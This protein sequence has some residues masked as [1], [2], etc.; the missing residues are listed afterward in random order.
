MKNIIITI[1]VLFSLSVAAQTPPT[2][3]KISNKTM[4]LGLGAD[5]TLIMPRYAA[6]PVGMRSGIPAVSGQI[7]LD[8]V[9]H[10]PYYFSDAWLRFGSVY[11]I[12]LGYGLSGTSPLTTTGT[13]VADTAT[14]FGDLYSTFNLTTTGT[15]AA[16][17]N[18]SVRTLN[19]PTPAAA[20]NANIGSGYRWAIPNTT[21]IKTFFVT[22]PVTI[23]STTNT[24]ALT[25]GLDTASGKWR[26]ENYYNTI[27]TPLTRSI[28][29]GYGLTGGGN[30]SA[31]RTFIADSATLF[32]NLI[33]TISLTTTGTSGAATWNTS[34]RTLNIPQYQAAGSYV[35]NVT[36]TYPAASSGGATPDISIDTSSGKWRSENY[37]NTVYTPL[38]RSLVKG[39]GIANTLGNFT[40]DRTVTVDSATIF[41]NLLSTVA[42]TT[43]GTTGA[44]TWN[45][46]TRILN[47]PNYSAGVADV[48][49]SDGSGFDFTITGTTT[50]NIALT[51]SLTLGSVPFIGASGALSQD[52][53]QL[54]WDDTDN[55]LG[56]GLNSPAYKLDVLANDAED[57]AANIYNSNGGGHGLR[58]DV[59]SSS[60]LSIFTAFAGSSAR[61][62]VRSDGTVLFNNQAGTSGYSLLSRGNGAPPVWKL[63]DTSNVNEVEDLV[64]TAF[65]G[66]LTVEL[67][68]AGGS[69]IGDF[70]LVEGTGIDLDQTGTTSASGVSVI[71]ISS[72]YAGQTSITTLGTIGTGTWQ[73][74]SISTTY[75]D[76]KLKTLTGTADR[77][78]I[79]GTS[80]DPTVDIASTYVG[81]SSITTLGTIGAGTWQGTSISTTY[82]D[83][84]IKTVTGTSDRLTI[85]GTST[86]PTFDISTSYVGQ[87]T[88]TTVGTIT[89]GVWNGTDIAYSNI[90]QL[91]AVSLLGNST[92]STATVGAISLGAGL[93][94]SG[95]SLVAA[96]ASDTN[97]IQTFSSSG[98]ASS[99]TWT[100]ASG[101]SL[102][103]IA[104]TNITFDIGG[105]SSDPTITINASLASPNP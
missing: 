79:G 71:S 93:S 61:F 64:S 57:Y 6:E 84:K 66:Q 45:P 38:T 95:G 65:A 33:S 78:T 88:I 48:T 87:N 17:W 34:T 23:D 35:T 101:G 99:L 42:L 27:Y 28:S 62:D 82:T 91:A 31:N 25:V 21:N 37:Y 86:D 98:D 7:A 18:A 4:H 15:G 46:T 60:N 77:I 83:A 92:G 90:E 14:M 63:A 50:K 100:L 76:A 13:I 74:T 24:N 43:T 59:N 102:Q 85:G 68:S 58:V 70:A 44:A 41:P 47:I 22:A 49:A 9:N 16:T 30:F 26:S 11:N 72:T 1:L 32:P 54:F 69:L 103:L 20:S 94:F 29:T 36:A 10:R 67:K 75:T 81:Q 12:V 105:T 80:T 3:T 96:D 53:A 8:T 39:Y 51:T 19:I 104:G 97:E 56:V 73:G 89:T 55:Y 5:S 40:T 52:N 2:F